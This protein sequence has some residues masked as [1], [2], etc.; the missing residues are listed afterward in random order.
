MA[1]NVSMLNLNTNLNSTLSPTVVNALVD[2]VNSK[3]AE[4]DRLIEKVIADL[5]QTY[6]TYE[7]ARKD[8]STEEVTLGYL[9]GKM[10]AFEEVLHDLKP[11]EGVAEALRRAEK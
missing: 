2:I 1:Y 11:Y 4:K 9:R 5:T 10:F 6:R 8:S 7:I 3:E